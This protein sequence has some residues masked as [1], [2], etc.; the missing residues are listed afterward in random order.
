MVSS[1]DNIIHIEKQVNYMSR[2]YENEKVVVSTKSMKSKINK[3][4]LTKLQELSMEYTTIAQKT[5]EFIALTPS[6]SPHA[7]EH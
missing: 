7:S 2:V 3:S 1:D 5:V 6:W 4:L